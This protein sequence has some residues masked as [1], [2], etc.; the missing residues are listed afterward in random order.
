MGKKSSKQNKGGRPKLP[1]SERRTQHTAARL[2]VEEFELL[3]QAA[4]LDE[5]SLS[6]WLREVAVSEAKKRIRAAR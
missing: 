6:D 2:T 4:D 1:A 5:M 3:R